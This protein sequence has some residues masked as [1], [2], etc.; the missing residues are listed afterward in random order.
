[1]KKV[2]LI[3][4][5]I[6]FKLTNCYLFSIIISIYNTARYLDDSIG[7]LLNQTIG[8]EAIQ[9]I[10]VNDGSTDN[11]ED[12]CLKYKKLFEKNIIYIKI[13][14]CGV[15]QARN[16]GLNFAKGKYI[17]FLDSDDKWDS[18]AFIYIHMFFEMHN[19][20]DIIG[21]RI[22]LFGARNNYHFLD[23]K[24]NST[25]VV[26]LTQEYNCIQ[27]SASSSF[28]RRTSIKQNKFKPNVYFGEDIRFIHNILFI[29]PL[30]GLVREVIY[31]YRKRSDSSSAIQNTEKNKEYY[32]STINSVHQ[33][34]IDKSYSLY[35]KIAPFIQFFI[36]YD[37]LFRL[38]SLAYNYLDTSNYSKYC[39]TIENLLRQ[40]DDKYILEQNVLSSRIKIYAL[41]KK[42][43]KDI[44]YDMVL[45][46]NY[47]KYSNYQMIDLKKYNNIIVWR[48]LEIKGHNIH[49]EGEDKFWLP[50]ERFNYFCKIGNEKFFPIYYYCS[51]YD[52]KTM[53][54]IIDK[55]RI[56]SFNLKLET[57]DLHQIHFYISFSNNSIEIFPSFNIFVHKLKEKANKK[58]IY[59]IIIFFQLFLILKLLLRMK[60]IKLLEDSK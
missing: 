54:G 18:H 38:S 4:Y 39:D 24:F 50:R 45:R 25:R 47:I 2:L 46:S 55:G 5:F 8:I 20:I 58:D 40:V 19:D 41:S 22:K 28:F 21:G 10:L 6:L 12:I 15:S 42:Y 14:H 33:Y 57:K 34:L 30:I 29:N 59:Y 16:V 9:I 11:S 32:F 3:I 48:K 52:F 31:Y 7:S 1:M 35:N 51:D 36:A 26:N 37:I 23:Y 44:R 49:L 60:I 53:Y 27:L 56:V 13:E 43:N 17:N